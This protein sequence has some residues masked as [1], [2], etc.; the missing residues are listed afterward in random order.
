MKK[1]LIILA[2]ALMGLTSCNKQQQQGGNRTQG[3]GQPGAAAGG[4]GQAPKR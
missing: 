1:T 2:V 4:N 3:G